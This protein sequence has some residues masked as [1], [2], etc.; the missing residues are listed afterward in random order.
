[1]SHNYPFLPTLTFERI[2]VVIKALRDVL[3]W[4]KVIFDMFEGSPT[5]PHPPT[6]G[7]NKPTRDSL[8]S[9]QFN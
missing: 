8:C 4:F 3:G 6:I 1:M 5:L 9:F 2:S 7:V